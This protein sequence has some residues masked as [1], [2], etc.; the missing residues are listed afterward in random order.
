M[1]KTYQCKTCKKYNIDKANKKYCGGQ[2]QVGT[3]AYNHWRLQAKL[4]Y[5]PKTKEDNFLANKDAC[6]WL[7]M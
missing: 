2:R 1:K 6:A 4:K 7:N 5:K 3:C